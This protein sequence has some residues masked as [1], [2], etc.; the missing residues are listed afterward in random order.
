MK[1]A[2]LTLLVLFLWALPGR[3]E[4]YAIIKDTLFGAQK[5]EFYSSKEKALKH[6]T[7]EGKIYRIVRTEV[8]VKKIETRKKVEVTENIWIIDE[9]KGKKTR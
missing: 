2:V 5:I 4:E 9:G 7:G 3:S 1:K 8:P 6:Y